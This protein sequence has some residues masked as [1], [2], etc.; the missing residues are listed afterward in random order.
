MYIPLSPCLYANIACIKI[1]ILCCFIFSQSIWKDIRSLVALARW[2]LSIKSQLNRNVKGKPTFMKN[3][4][5]ILVVFIYCYFCHTVFTQLYY[6]FRSSPPEQNG[7][8]FAD[9]IF[10]CIV[11][12]ET[13]NILIQISLKFVPRVLQTRSQV[14]FRYCLR[15]KQVP[16][17]YLNQCWPSSLTHILGTKWSWVE[18]GGISWK[19]NNRCL[20][21]DVNVF[22]KSII[23]FN[24][25][26]AGIY[27]LISY[28]IPSRDYN[29]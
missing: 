10:K 25:M 24:Q 6:I 5:K 29:W 18:L 23:S 2:C 20:Y 17:H 4:K 22:S 1:P 11:L 21:A 28:Y 13:L 19:S 15:A 9:D 27:M 8:H 16:S 7:R 14:W 3:I 26:Y 12:E